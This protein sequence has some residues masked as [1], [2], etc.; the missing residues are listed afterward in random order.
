MDGDFVPK[1]IPTCTRRLSKVCGIIELTRPWSRPH[2]FFTTTQKYSARAPVKNLN[3]LK[4]LKTLKNPF[5]NAKELQTPNALNVHLNHIPKN[6]Y[7]DK[8]ESINMFKIN[9]GKYSFVA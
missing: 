7:G 5:E 4:N 3:N 6:V 2:I 9:Y 8:S 1:K